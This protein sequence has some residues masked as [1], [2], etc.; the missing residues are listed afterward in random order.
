MIT[1]KACNGL[2]HLNYGTQHDAKGC[3]VCAGGGLT[4]TRLGH[5]YLAH[6]L[7]AGVDRDANIARA[8]RWFAWLSDLGFLVHAPWILLAQVWTEE[9]RAQGLEIDR[10]F[11]DFLGALN[12]VSRSDF[13]IA[14]TGGRI[15]PGMT[16]ERDWASDVGLRI[17]DLTFLGPE[18]PASSAR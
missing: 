3:F 1:C 8:T 18:P 16:D 6:P 17:I 7:G 12:A 4:R 11:I 14:L 2:G 10:R 5:L 15:S 9:R 13:S